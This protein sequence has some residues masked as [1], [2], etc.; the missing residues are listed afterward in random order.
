MFPCDPGAALSHTA[1]RRRLA[2]E[3]ELVLHAHITAIYSFILGFHIFRN[4]YIWPLACSVRRFHETRAWRLIEQE[5]QTTVG[6]P[7]DTLLHATVLV[8]FIPNGPETPSLDRYPTSPL[9]TAQ[10]LNIF[11]T[12]KLIPERLDLIY[13]FVSMKGG[14]NAIAFQGLRDVL[15]M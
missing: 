15:R 8:G 1:H 12:A 10:L 6:P 14:L 7:S 5:T 9:A 3:H 2:R 13:H 4:N 11:G